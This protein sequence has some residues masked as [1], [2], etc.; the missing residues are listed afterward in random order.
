MHLSDR[1]A[2]CPDPLS[3]K[4]T[5]DAFAASAGLAT[6]VRPVEISREAAANTV[7]SGP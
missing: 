6:I 2:T 1:M 3:T 5:R 7:P 4:P